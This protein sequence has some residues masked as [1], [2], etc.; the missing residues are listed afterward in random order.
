MRQSE[1]HNVTPYVRRHKCVNT[2]I[3]KL[4]SGKLKDDDFCEFMSA[5]INKNWENLTPNDFVS[6]VE[7]NDLPLV[8]HAWLHNA[9]AD[10]YVFYLRNSDEYVVRAN[11]MAGKIKIK[12]GWSN[13]IQTL[14]I[15]RID[16]KNLKALKRIGESI[17][18]IQASRDR[19]SDILTYLDITTAP[20]FDVYDEAVD[21]IISLHFVRTRYT[22]DASRKSFASRILSKCTAKISKIK[23]TQSMCARAIKNLDNAYFSMKLAVDASSEVRHRTGFTQSY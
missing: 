20:I 11:N 18:R 6:L 5:K 9:F 2:I 12:K 21:H 7:R 19:L 13:D 17:E 22:S 10:F 14:S 15:G 1:K 23:S 16:V 8:A 3:A 4:N